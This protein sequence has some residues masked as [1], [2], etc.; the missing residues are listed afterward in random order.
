MFVQTGL[1]I[2]GPNAKK[3]NTRTGQALQAMFDAHQPDEWYFG[4]WHH[5]MQYKYGRT[6][7]QCIGELDYTD[8]EL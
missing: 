3:I 5:T 7:F 6:M 2:G 1:A 8:V 4:H